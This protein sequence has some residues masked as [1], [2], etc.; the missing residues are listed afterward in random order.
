MNAVLREYLLKGLFLGLW[1]YTALV[2]P[3]AAGFGRVVAWTA[4]GLAVG[5]LAGAAL[6]LLRGYRP[7]ANPAGFLLLTLLDSPYFIYLG[8]IGGAAVGI[9]TERPTADVNPIRDWLLYFAAGGAVLGVGFYQL[10][11][12]KEWVWR[13]GLGLTVGGLLIYAAIL[14]LNDVSTFAA[15]VDL[16]TFAAYLL[17]GLPFF[18]VLTF[19]GETEES[20]VEIAALCAGLG[21]GL[22]LL[23]LSSSLPEIG[24]KL[25]FLV[26][27]ALYF[28]Y[29]TRVLPGLR[30]FKHTLRGYGYLSLGRVRESLACFGRALQLDPKNA[31][32]TQGMW[33]LHRRI[34]VTRLD[35]DTAGLLNFDFCLSMASDTLIGPQPPTEE[36]RVSAVRVLDV[37]ERRRPEL[38][39]RIDYLR[40]VASTHAKEFDAAAEA[41]S[42]LLNPENPANAA[43]R[44]KV[45]FPAWDLALRLHPELVKRLGTAELAKPGRRLEAIR[46]VERQLAAA[47]DDP[48]ATELKR[49]LY[50]GL[51]ESEFAAAVS[52]PLAER[53]DA[54][55][56]PS[57]DAAEIRSRSERTTLL[58][59]LNYDYIEQLGLALVDDSDPAQVERGMAYLR[60][61]GR[62]LPHRGPS[63]FSRLADLAAK[64]G[65]ADETRG[66]LEQVKRAA[67]TAGPANLPTEERALY[68]SA[69]R[70]LV[71]D[72]EVRGDFEAAV[73]DQRLFIEA[74][75]ETVETLRRLADLNVKTGD[76]L[77]ALLIVERGLLYAGKD[78]D[79]L[80]KKASY[81]RSVEVE[82]V[83]AVK[84]KVASWFDVG[85]CVKTA[86]KVADQTEPDA[87]TLDWG[88]HL[89]RLA[90][91]VKPESHAAMFTEARLRLRLG[92]PDEG[93]RLL[94]DLHEQ[95]RGS[96]EDEDAWF[97]AAR[98]L[99]DIYLDEV[100]RP[101]LAIQCFKDF[102]ESDKSGADTLYRLAQAYE[103][104]GDVP[105][106]ICNFEAVTA[107][108]NHPRYWDAKEAIRRLKGSSVV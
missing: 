58:P 7:A 101:D 83:A 13:F 103:A 104:N 68:L 25:I 23:R 69:L 35:D 85:Y 56:F 105:N 54:N 107:Y 86:Q 79:L 106:A 50:S 96:G 31:L 27:L 46:A 3:D 38:L 2:Q 9:L 72:A 66:Y 61:A 65:R 1:A 102:R 94:E 89:I 21:I 39:P 62:G 10:S 32:A 60:I 70:K 36:Q 77:N 12:V 5:L 41:L 87:E 52:G 93:L 59:D 73:G 45:L 37:V 20:E 48:T 81:Y 75:N 44:D 40:A 100:G 18:Y 53:A 14:Y 17:V 43:E 34:D 91:T 74:G 64:L 99:G 22:Y 51:T 4:G 28:V 11:R 33:K 16:R 67:L 15:A 63:I 71:D 47:P 88:L 8:L 55:D 6:Q 82:R 98:K 42:R 84:D 90:R 76:V 57:N 78:P 108:Q 24:D 97:Y 80:D 19:C 30:V 92:K 95:K 26:P 49:E 29:A